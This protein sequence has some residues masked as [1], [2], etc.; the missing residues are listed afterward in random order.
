MHKKY[1]TQNFVQ[2]LRPFVN[3]LPQ[4][5]KKNLKKRGYN[6]TSIVDNWSKIVGGDISECCYPTKVKVG[7]SLD[8]GVLM[9][10]V[11]HGKE[12]VVE[13]KKRE[14]IDKIN[15][16][17]GYNYLEKISL[18]LVHSEQKQTKKSF[19]KSKKNN[20]FDN[21]IKKISNS[22]LKKLMD[23]LIKAYNDKKNL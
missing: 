20:D 22:D 1:N 6:F 18:N 4:G 19:F 8:A 9:L 11:V 23:K 10:N 13:Y 15:S 21:V 12:L 3:S 5:I 16:F 7:K 14:I 17:F 2:G